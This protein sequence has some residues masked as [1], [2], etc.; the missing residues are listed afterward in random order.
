[1][2]NKELMRELLAEKD[3]ETLLRRV[4]SLDPKI[5]STLIG[6]SGH[7]ELISHIAKTMRDNPEIRKKIQ[8]G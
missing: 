1:M 3:P 7:N 2:D 6:V 4:H 5:L 8:N